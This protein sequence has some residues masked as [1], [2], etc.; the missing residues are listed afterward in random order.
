VTAEILVVDLNG[1]ITPPLCAALAQHGYAPI[2]S[3]Y[4]EVLSVAEHR[5]FD[6]VVTEIPPEPSGTAMC[7]HL[8]HLRPDVPIV[9]TGDGDVD[10]V[11]AALRSGAY[12]Y[13]IMPAAVD[14]LVAAVGRAVQHRRLLAEVQR[15]RSLPHAVSEPLIGDSPSIRMVKDLLLQVADSDATVLI[16]GESGTGKER[17]ARA[18]HALS[19]RAAQPF[20]AM[21]S[22]AMPASL[23]ESELFG[24][25][26]GAF[27]DAVRTRPG[28]LAAAER[29]T[30][31][32]D[33]IGDMPLGI[34]SKLL[35]ALQERRFRP[36]GSDTELP[37][38]A[39]LV[40]AT[41]RNLEADVP[42]GRFRQELYYRINV[43]QI[44]MPPL[45]ER[46]ED[47]LPLAQHILNRVAARTG[48]P[49]DSISPPAAQRLIE[50]DWPGNVRELENCIERAVL[51][52]SF[53]E[54]GVD[55][56]PDRVRVAR[57]GAAALS[58]AHPNLVSLAEMKRR[59]LRHVV[60]T[61]RGNKSRAARI[62]DIDRRTLCKHLR[63][64]L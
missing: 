30:V 43:I 10:T 7:A 47:V 40:A 12:D 45:R 54:I 58:A 21:N 22:A 19:P 55:D 24:H 41:N 33:E 28:L 37:L 16:T 35:R 15:L 46:R 29:G 9:A 52:T 14:T 11:V 17:A 23:L 32:L 53:T 1:G 61:V 56:L 39:R 62:L 8:R 51:L 25:M 31:F 48:K 18:L 2:A 27:T 57:D 50:Y 34:Q 59:Y 44:A 49:V 26:R 42:S 3:R 6:A 36:V 4:P 64:E 13:V 5:A 38:L 20:V 60:A 63:D